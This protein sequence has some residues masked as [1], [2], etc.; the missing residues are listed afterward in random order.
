MPTMADIR[1]GVSVVTAPALEPI[2]YAQAKA[3]LQLT[4]DDLT[5]WLTDRIVAARQKVERDTGRALITQTLDVVLSAFPDDG[6]IEFPVM[7]IASVTSITVTN[8]AGV[9]AVFASSNYI[10]DLT[11]PVP[12]VVLADGASWP[13]DV[14]RAAGIVVRCV[15]GYGATAAAVDGPLVLAIE[16]LI[17]EWYAV[18][19]GAQYVPPRRWLGYEATIAP[20]RVPRVG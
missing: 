16:Q 14:R 18:H 8:T 11:G 10:A 17:A 6:V 1:V 9:S 13:T 12:R 4:H 2:T 20:Y 7:P 19:V 15:A 3:L 5:T